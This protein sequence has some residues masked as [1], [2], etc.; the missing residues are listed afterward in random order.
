MPGDNAL[1]TPK[2][3]PTPTPTPT[4]AQRYRARFQRVLRHIDDHPDGDLSVAALSAV[5]AFSPHHFHRQFTALFGIGIHR[6]VQLLRFKRAGHR[7]AFRTDPILTIALDAGYDGPEAFARAFKRC[8]GQSPSA[9]RAAP[10]WAAWRAVQSDLLPI[11]RFTMT[12]QPPPDATDIRIITVPDIPVAVL[13]HR[14]DPARIGDSVRRFI[15]WRKANGLP[16]QRHATYNILHDDPEQVPPDDFRLDLCVATDRAVE[17]NPDGVRTGVIPGGRCATL[18]H[19]GS[20]AGLRAALLHLYRD[21]LPASGEE[22]GDAPPYLQ[23]VRFF[24][25]V[26]ETEAVTDLFLPLAG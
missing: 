11:E 9:F 5:A 21:W 18:R 16:P 13:E 25:D 4:A 19:V 2:P 8:V 1:T 14:G 12:D 20:E 7:L 10:D 15:D 6:C 26:P 23:R 3:T 22:P 24:P 17:P